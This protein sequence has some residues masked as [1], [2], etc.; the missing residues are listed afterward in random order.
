MANRIVVDPSGMGLVINLIEDGV[1]THGI[2]FAMGD[3]QDLEPR[4]LKI[5]SAMAWQIWETDRVIAALEQRER[6]K[7]VAMPYQHAN[8]REPDYPDKH[9]WHCQCGKW[10]KSGYIG[11]AGPL[12]PE[13]D[14]HVEKCVYDAVHA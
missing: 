10:D 11:T 1:L 12:P 14:E 8:F 13:F 9:G 4:Y 5:I 6:E 3:G 7:H 2:S